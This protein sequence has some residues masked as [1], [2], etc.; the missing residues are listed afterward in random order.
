MQY[1]TTD[2][3]MR[4][5][6]QMAH[7]IRDEISILQTAADYLIND[8]TIPA[9]ARDKITLLKGHLGSVAGIARQFLILTDNESNQLTV[10]DVGEVISQ[11][12]PLLQRL[13]DERHQLQIVLAPDLWPIKADLMQFEELFCALIANARDA[14]PIGGT[15]SISAT[16][17]TKAE[18]ETKP[19]TTTIAADYV[20]IK[21]ADTGHGIGKD[22]IDRIFEPF[23]T[24]KRPGCGFG[25]AKVYATIKK[26]NGHIMVESDIARGAIFRIYIPRHVPI[27]V[28]QS[29]P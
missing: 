16:N 17:M 18:C 25:L 24:T 29:H 11:L 6:P 27:M 26:I 28:D 5:A 10:L 22:I 12:T 4:L 23:F 19:E 15:F 21:V 8:Q 7:R 3:F 9:Q 20:L 14:M 13:V 2:E 1:V